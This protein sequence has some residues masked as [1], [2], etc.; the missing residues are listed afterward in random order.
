MKYCL[1][2][3]HVLDQT[4]IDREVNSVVAGE[5][6]CNPNWVKDVCERFGISRA[7]M[8]RI[9]ERSRND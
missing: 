1:N 6:V 5:R 2:C 7:T 3:S 4:E 8:Y 9:L